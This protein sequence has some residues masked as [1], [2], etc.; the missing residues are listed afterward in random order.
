MGKRAHGELG[1]AQKNFARPSEGERAGGESA[2]VNSGSD[3]GDNVQ[4]ARAEAKGEKK[5]TVVLVNGVK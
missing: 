3:E 2:I 5:R 1:Q 4:L